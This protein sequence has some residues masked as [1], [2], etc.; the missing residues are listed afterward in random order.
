MI[1]SF[2]VLL[3]AL[4]SLGGYAQNRVSPGYMDSI[5][6]F[7]AD[8]IQTHELLTTPE[9][10][11]LLRFYPLDPSYRVVAHYGRLTFVIRD[12]TI[13]LM[14]YQSQALMQKAETRDYLFVPFTDATSGVDS[15]DAGRYIDC[16]VND[17]HTAYQNPS[18]NP[19]GRKSGQHTA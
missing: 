2:L 13:R 1:K 19:H 15:Y 10:K 14:I 12:T 9:Q 17:I 7:R 8:Y 18:L 4:G 6:A 16:Q 11:A 5:K 3:L